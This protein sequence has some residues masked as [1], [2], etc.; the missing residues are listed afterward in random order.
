MRIPAAAWRLTR[1]YR[2]LQPRQ[3]RATTCGLGYDCPETALGGNP[4]TK[5]CGPDTTKKIARIV[6]DAR[7]FAL[8]LGLG[9]RRS[10]QLPIYYGPCTLNSVPAVSAVFNSAWVTPTRV[11]AVPSGRMTTVLAFRLTVVA[12]VRSRRL[13]V[14]RQILAL[15]EQ[16]VGGVLKP[17][18]VRRRCRPRCLERRPPRYVVDAPVVAAEPDRTGTTVS[19]WSI[20][21]SQPTPNVPG[22]DPVAAAAEDQIG[23]CWW[24]GSC[25]R[26]I[27]VL[28]RKEK[29]LIVA[30]P[31]LPDRLIRSPFPATLLGLKL[32]L[33][34]LPPVTVLPATELAL[35]LSAVRAAGAD[36]DQHRP[37]LH[38]RY[39]WRR[40]RR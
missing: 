27:A 33:C 20:G 30:V 15:V 39:W 16:E 18:T 31:W 12:C 35:P 34:R 24:R 19:A 3:T 5:C 10:A 7:D 17:P 2:Q 13:P 23:C 14:R 4:A 11:I 1:A 9:R 40:C 8:Q 28:P 22:A 26:G 29:A 36:L 38:P 6:A 25:R 32:K 37:R 21:G